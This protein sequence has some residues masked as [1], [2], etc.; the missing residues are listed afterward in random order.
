MRERVQLHI[1]MM[2]VFLQLAGTTVSLIN[3]VF[4]V[5][6]ILSNYRGILLDLLLTT[7]NFENT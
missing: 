6:H 5:A 4:Q 3:N 2:T 7:F 1:E